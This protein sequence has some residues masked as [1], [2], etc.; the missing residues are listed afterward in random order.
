MKFKRLNI[1]ILAIVFV[2]VIAWVIYEDG[3]DNILR[4]FGMLQPLWMSCAVLMM[5]FYWL[6]ESWILHGIVKS[7]YDKQRFR[8]SLTTSMIGQLFN[9]VTPFSSGGQPI[10]AYHMTRTGVPLG[11]AGGA[12][13][14]KFI[15]YQICLTIYSI[16]MLLFF[17]KP[18]SA[19]VSGFGYLTFV[20]F[21]INSAVLLLLGA[22]CFFRGFTSRASHGLVH[23]LAR[24]HLVKDREKTDRYIEEQLEEF[25]A[26]FL[27][28]RRHP[29]MMIRASILSLLQLTVFFLVP[30]FI[31][32][33][34]GIRG[35]PIPMA[36]AAQS[37]V[38]MISSFVPLPGAAGGA[39]YSFHTFFS[40]FF[41]ASEAGINLAMLLWRLLTFYLPIL[42]GACFM[43]GTPREEKD[44]IRKDRVQMI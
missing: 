39:E 38:V 42:V 19:N 36:L 5:V 26:S 1:A 21:A 34:F 8:D 3:W 14:I 12:L 28:I 33:A 2:G 7:F 29:G 17:W 15:V 44:A 13:M 18:L 6:L 30:Y 43:I 41:A 35:I 9:C 40:G 23:V 10:Q 32:L 20:G 31:C 24:I 11:V 37:F 4:M 25:H 27:A 16:V 22:I